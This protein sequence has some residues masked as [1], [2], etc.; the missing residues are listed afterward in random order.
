MKKLFVLLTVMV[1]VVGF[2][3]GAFAQCTNCK[4]P[5][6][7]VPCPL[8]ADQGATVDCTWFDYDLNDDTA[9]GPDLTA[10]GYCLYD[11]TDPVEYRAILRVCDC[12]ETATIFN[13]PDV[14]IR[15]TILV[16]GVAGNAGVTWADTQPATIDLDSF[17]NTTEACDLTHAWTVDG[18]FGAPTYYD[19]DGNAIAPGDLDLPDA[20]DT[21]CTFTGYTPSSVLFTEGA[22]AGFNAVGYT[23]GIWWIDIPPIRTNPNVLND[24]EVISVQIELVDLPCPTCVLCECTIPVAQVCCTAVTSDCLLFPYFTSLTADTWWNG[25]AIVNTSSTDGSADLTAYEADGSVA[26]ATVDVAAHSMFCDVLENIAWSGTGLGGSRLYIEVE[27]DF[28]AD[29]F[30]MMGNGMEAQGGLPRK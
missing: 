7:N 18:S 14:G 4:G 6:R 24:G 3:S 12:A 22:G 29:G 21:A 23:E 17:V 15:M 25:I 27:T 19:S 11:G 28:E 20:A 2:T 10:D 30:F 9:A 16:D 1:A 8:V 13:T 5:I 26:T